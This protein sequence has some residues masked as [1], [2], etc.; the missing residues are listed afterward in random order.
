MNKRITIVQCSSRSAGDTGMLSQYILDNNNIRFLDL[1]SKQIAQYRY[2]D[3]NLGDDFL[4]T[5]SELITESD[6]MIF[7]TPIYWYSMSGLMKTFFDRISELLKDEK[8]LGRQLRGKYLGYMSMSND[9]SIDY[10]FDI[11]IRKSASYLGMHYVGYVHCCVENGNLT[12]DTKLK[13]DDYINL[14]K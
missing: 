7:L 13:V 10:D 8:A 6:V 12:T 3:A 11:P 1:N 5:I 9:R 4:P 2:D 14:L